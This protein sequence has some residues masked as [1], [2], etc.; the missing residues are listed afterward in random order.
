[1]RPLADMVAAAE[2]REGDLRFA[3]MRMRH[4]A[5]EIALAQG[6]PAELVRVDGLLHGLK[7]SLL[8]VTRQRWVVG[9]VSKCLDYGGMLVNYGC[10][11]W[12]VL[13]TGASCVGVV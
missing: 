6:G 12:I 2:R 1:M 13:R 9:A 10:I 4:H 5:M 3:H 7:T 11:A 8:Q